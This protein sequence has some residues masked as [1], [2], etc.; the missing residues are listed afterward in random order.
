MV[1]LTGFGGE[2]NVKKTQKKSNMT[3]VFDLSKEGDA[4]SWDFRKP[5][6]EQTWCKLNPALDMLSFEIRINYPNGDID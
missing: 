5:V 2:L 1:K 3:P 6:E 4:I